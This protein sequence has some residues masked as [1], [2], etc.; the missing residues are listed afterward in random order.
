[1]TEVLDGLRE[2]EA[3]RNI[4]YDELVERFKTMTEPD[5]PAAPQKVTAVRSVYTQG[6][7]LRAFVRQLSSQQKF[8]NSVTKLRSLLGTARTGGSPPNLFDALE[9]A[10]NQRLVALKRTDK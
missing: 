2:L 6:S 9:D 8:S 7:D 10:L 4:Y 5:A 3:A 1:E